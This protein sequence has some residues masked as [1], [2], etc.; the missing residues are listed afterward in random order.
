M[1]RTTIEELK[2][3]RLAAMTADKRAAFDETYETGR[4]ALN[5]GE[6]VRGAR[7]RRSR[8]YDAVHLA[9]AM[10]ALD[11]E[12]VL[13]TGDNDLA[14]QHERRACQSRSPVDSLHPGPEVA[15][16]PCHRRVARPRLGAADLGTLGAD[17]A[18]HR[19]V[20]GSGRPPTS[21]GGCA[22][23]EIGTP[24]ADRSGMITGR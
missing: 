3:N 8:G 21:R 11:A 10:V 17:T 7:C 12:L 24:N 5:V 20:N 6:K 1:A 2:K 15:S 16:C 4:L 23:A 14:G 9:A 19:D 22:I 18:S 13:V